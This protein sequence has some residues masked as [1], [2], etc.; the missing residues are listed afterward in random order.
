MSDL[1][2]F[3]ITNEKTSEL[4]SLYAA[5]EKDLQKLIESNMDSLL[6]VRFLAS[7]YATG[8][9]HSGRIDSLGIDENSCPVI[10]EYKRHSNENVINQG[11]YYLDW[12]LDHQ[13]EFQLLVQEKYGKEISTSIEWAGTRLI[14]IASD[15]NKFDRYAVQQND[16][17]IELMRYGFF[18]EDLLLLELVNAQ[19]ASPKANSSPNLSRSTPVSTREAKERK[20]THEYRKEAASSEHMRLYDLVCEYAESLGDDVQRK[21]LKFYTA[22]KRIKNFVSVQIWAPTQDPTVLLYL[23]LNPQEF[24]LEEG[25]SADATNKGH[26]GTGDLEIRIKTPADIEKAKKFIAKS[27]LVN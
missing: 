12:L 16:K 26:W 5:Y 4:E 18:G 19:T 17:N 23:K 24:D 14:C 20:D 21:E 10:I 3:T 22:F 2:L 7:E 8:R 11:L 6:G 13:G 1:K 15:Y 27:F 9:T 25:F